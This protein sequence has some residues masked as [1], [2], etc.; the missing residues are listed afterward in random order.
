MLNVGKLGAILKELTSLVK[1]AYPEARKGAHFN[2]GI[3]F[4]DIKSLSYELKEIVAPW[5]QEGA[6]TIS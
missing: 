2:S 1:G 4:M 3:V 6:L 5:L